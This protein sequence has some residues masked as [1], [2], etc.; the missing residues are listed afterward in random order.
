VPQPQCACH[1]RISVSCISCWLV[2]RMQACTGSDMQAALRGLAVAGRHL[3]LP[4][5]ISGSKSLRNVPAASQ[6]D[7]SAASQ[8][9]SLATRAAQGSV[10]A[11]T[12][13]TAASAGVRPVPGA[14]TFQEAI[15]RLQQYW[16]G[17]GCALWLPHNTEVR[18]PACWHQGHACGWPTD[19]LMAAKQAACRLVTL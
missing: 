14:P 7:G 18:L 15:S 17:V 12:A 13:P 6:R 8:R 3:P 5:L 9:S 16:A 10:E 19:P 11:P 1:N 4:R 2:E